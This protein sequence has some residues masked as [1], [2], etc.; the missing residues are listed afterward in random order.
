MKVV[1]RTRRL[2]G[3]I[4]TR[5]PKEVVKKLNL[6]ENEE[7]EMDVK[8]HKKSFFG[9]IKGITEFQEEDRFDRKDISD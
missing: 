7:I 6:E 3:S 9:A 8:K 5:I 1:V 2:G 4:I